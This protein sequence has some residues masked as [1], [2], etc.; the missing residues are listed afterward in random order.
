MLA[1][2]VSAQGSSCNIAALTRHM[3][4][5]VTCRC[6]AGLDRLAVGTRTPFNAMLIHTRH[7]W[8]SRPSCPS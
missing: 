3:Q 1:L 5:A 4:S 8:A 6:P 2:H 7:A